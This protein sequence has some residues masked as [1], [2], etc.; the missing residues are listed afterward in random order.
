MFLGSKEATN[1]ACARTKTA[2]IVK[3]MAEKEIGDV[4]SLRSV[5]FF[6]AT[7]GSNDVGNDAMLYPIVVMLCN[8]TIRTALLT[9][10][11]LEGNPTGHNV[12][13]LVVETLK[14]ENIPIWNCIGMACDNAPVMIGSKNNVA[15]VV[16]EN[17]KNILPSLDVAVI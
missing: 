9:M 2:V 1:Y 13:A 3:E 14:N 7:D 10:I 6:V 5:P 4:S 8:R 12:G 11:A 16:K 17:H 15:A